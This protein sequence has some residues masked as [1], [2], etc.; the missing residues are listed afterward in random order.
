MTQADYKVREALIALMCVG[1]KI[2]HLHGQDEESNYPMKVIR[3]C[4]I[5]EIHDNMI[6]VIDRTNS[7]YFVKKEFIDEHDGKL[8][9]WNAMGWYGA[10]T[11]EKRIAKMD[12]L[13]DSPSIL[14]W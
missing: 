14:R 1:D 2:F 5:L 9:I 7:P 8:Y 6:K 3:T 13:I 12:R 11:Y 4:K 10:N